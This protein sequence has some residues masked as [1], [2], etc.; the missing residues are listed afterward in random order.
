VRGLP[1]S[2]GPRVR[3]AGLV[4]MALVDFL[5]DSDGSGLLAAWGWP[6]TPVVFPEVSCRRAAAKAAAM[7]SSFQPHLVSILVEVALV[8]L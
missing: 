1:G 8:L 2:N 6:C 7:E 3:K 4:H 5:P